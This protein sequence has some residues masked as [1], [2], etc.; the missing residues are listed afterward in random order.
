MKLQALSDNLVLKPIMAGQ[1]S[2]GGIVLP[3]T[4]RFED[5]CTIISIGPLV[6]TLAVGD[7]VVR[8][9]PPSMEITDDGTHEILWLCKESDILAR[10]V[11]DD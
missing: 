8:P 9:D 5:G 1:K 2:A 7:I 11:A 6:T 4:E 3:G 10:V